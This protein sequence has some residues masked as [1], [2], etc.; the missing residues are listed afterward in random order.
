VRPFMN[1]LPEVQP[2]ERKIPFKEKVLYTLH[3]KP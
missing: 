2:A 1:I 3:R